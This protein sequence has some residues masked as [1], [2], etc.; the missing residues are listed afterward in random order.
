M[1]ARKTAPKT[2][3]EAP[4]STESA[5]P[6]AAGSIALQVWMDLGTEAMRFVWDRLQQ[7]VKTPQAMLACTSLDELRSIQA[8]FFAA[9]Q[10]QYAAETGKVL[11]LLGRATAEGLSAAALRRGYDD[12]PL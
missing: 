7:D 2:P 12:V 6:L 3:A 1:P 8:E 10:Q 5:L 11:A 9:A 4:A